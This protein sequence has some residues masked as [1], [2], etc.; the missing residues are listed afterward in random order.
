[1]QSGYFDSSHARAL[2]TA[3]HNAASASARIELRM[4]ILPAAGLGG[5]AERAS[6]LEFG[7]ARVP[8]AARRAAA[9]RLHRQDDFIARFE[10][11]AV[12]AVA[13]QHARRATFQIPD[14][15]AAVRSF[16]LQQEIGV[17]IGVLELLNGADEFDR[18]F[19]I[20]HGKR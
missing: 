17:W 10:R 13:T 18:V 7:R 9:Q 19:L 3:A 15:R 1:A 2:V 5:D 11:G 12:P 14:R 20:E 4:T 16:H 8:R 6:V